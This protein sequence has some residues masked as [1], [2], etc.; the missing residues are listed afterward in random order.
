MHAGSAPRESRTL[1]IA[2]EIAAGGP[3][4][5][6]GT[7]TPTAVSPASVSWSLTA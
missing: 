4:S 6:V 5:P 3:A 2:S 1:G 7:A